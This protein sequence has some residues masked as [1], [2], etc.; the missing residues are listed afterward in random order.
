MQIDLLDKVLAV[1]E[2]FLAPGTAMAVPI[3][4]KSS[5]TVLPGFQGHFGSSF[6][7]RQVDSLQ[8][9]GRTE[10][11]HVQSMMLASP[12]DAFPRRI[13]S[14]RVFPAP[15]VAK[16]FTHGRPH[17]LQP[18]PVARDFPFPVGFQDLPEGPVH[19]RP[20]PRRLGLD[21]LRTELAEMRTAVFIETV[22]GLLLPQCALEIGEKQ[23]QSLGVIPDML[24]G[25]F[26]G[27]R[28][29]PDA[30]PSPD[31]AVLQAQTDGTD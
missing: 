30:L 24:A 5:E 22:L 1:E 3:L 19:T 17:F 13:P 14:V 20:E 12:Q 9:P 29:S 23:R 16:R 6:Q 8:P 28:R 18:G 2:I 26:A 31:R 21:A 7:G 10:E 11:L 4:A 15:G 27:T 25:P